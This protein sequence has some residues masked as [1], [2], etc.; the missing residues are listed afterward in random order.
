[1]ELKRDEN[2]AVVLQDDMPVYLNEDGKEVPVDVPGLFTKLTQLNH[3]N[4]GRRKKESELSQQLSKYADLDPDAARDAIQRLGALDEKGMVDSSKVESIKKQ[5]AETYEAKVKAEAEKAAGFEQ[6]LYDTLVSSSITGSKFLAD[7]TYLAPDI[8]AAYFGKH[9]AVQIQDGKPTVVATDSAGNPIMSSSNPTELAGV[10]EA[11]QTLINRH[12]DKGK[13][14]KA[15]QTGAGPTPKGGSGS[16]GG[17]GGKS[18]ANMN[19]A[20]RAAYTHEH[21]FEKAAQFS[22]QQ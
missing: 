9:F 11:L 20:E 1:M 14:L 3:E 5:M 16:S 10:D 2:G 22:K 12:P 19:A 13:F 7:N 8:A 17:H 4:A 15:G 21:G 18:W 6:M